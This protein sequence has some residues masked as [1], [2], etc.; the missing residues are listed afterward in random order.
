MRTEFHW[1]AIWNYNLA[2]QM[3]LSNVEPINTTPHPQEWELKQQFV[4]TP[5]ILNKCRSSLRTLAH[6]LRSLCLFRF[7]CPFNFPFYPDISQ[8]SKKDDQ[9]TS[10]RYGTLLQGLSS[11]FSIGQVQLLPFILCFVRVSEW[12]PC[13]LNSVLL[14]LYSIL[15][16]AACAVR[17][18]P[19]DCTSM[20][21]EFQSAT[22]FLGTSSSLK[23]NASK[24]ASRGSKQGGKGLRG[25]LLKWPKYQ[26]R[27]ILGR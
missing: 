20:L 18:S 11:P 5:G 3:A 12:W 4:S 23:H 27:N 21:P 22:S 7:L 15:S 25:L 2:A 26:K 9:W 13:C 16:R 19:S 1:F 8:I 14:L 10:L 24:T 17:F 6:H